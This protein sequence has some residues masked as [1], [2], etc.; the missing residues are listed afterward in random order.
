MV[1]QAMLSN[2]SV[3]VE[4][5]DKSAAFCVVFPDCVMIIIPNTIENKSENSVDKQNRHFIF[6]FV[7]IITKR[8]LK[9]KMK[10]QQA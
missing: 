6:I 4:N 9:R 8:K 5:S 1:L 2:A 7:R 10:Q 3:D